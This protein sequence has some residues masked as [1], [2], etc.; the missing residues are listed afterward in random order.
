MVNFHNTAFR[1]AIFKTCKL[2]GVAFNECNKLLL[3]VEFQDCQL[4]LSSF[5]KLNLKSTRFTN[6]NLQEVIFSEADLRESVFDNCNLSRA[7]FEYTNLE[8]SDFR[9]S[10]NYSIHPESNRIKKAKFSLP[11]VIGLL[12]QYNIEIE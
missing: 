10:F 12:D 6:C 8:K 2:L 1:G 4:N 11:G 9:S 7:E 5:L 3:S